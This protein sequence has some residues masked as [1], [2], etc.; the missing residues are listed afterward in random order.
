MNPKQM[1]WA[2]IALTSLAQVALKHGLMRIQR[3]SNG[4][5][6]LLVTMVK[7]GYIWLW[8]ACF[9]GGTA[10][11]LLG[12]RRLDLSYAYPL[13]SF[14]YVLVAAMAALFFRER[15]GKRWV[16]IAVICM[17]VYLISGS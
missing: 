9:A 6:R 12:L 14:G 4:G 11:W 5:L 7:E 16:A 1:I 8:G 17:G 2:S 13:L 3:E 10:L 15:I